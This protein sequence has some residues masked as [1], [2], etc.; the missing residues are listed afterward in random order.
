MA[1]FARLLI[2]F[3]IVTLALGVILLVG[4][5]IPLIGRLPGDILV[6]REGTTIFIPIATSLLLSLVLTVLLN[7][8]WR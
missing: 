2:V 1:D 3:G 6:R 4:P 7:L 5:K 8:F